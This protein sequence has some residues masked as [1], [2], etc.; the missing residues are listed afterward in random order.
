MKILIFGATGMLGHK[1]LQKF[2]GRFDVTATCRNEKGLN[3]SY[4]FERTNIINGVEVT[5][6]ATVSS[7]LQT[8]RPDVVVNA[9]G[10][11]KQLPG[12]RDVTTALKVNSLFPH[13]LATESEIHGFRLLTIS[14]DCVFDGKKGN[15]ADA[16]TPDALDLYGQSKRWGEVSA[17]NC[18]TLRTSIIGHELASSHSLVDWFL[19]NRGGSVKGFKSA[20]YSGFPTVIFADII[21]S[22]IEQQPK[23]SGIYNVS[24]E[25]INKFDLLRLIDEEYKSNIDIQPDTDFTIDRSLNS[26]RFRAETGFSPLSWPEMI[27]SMREDSSVYGIK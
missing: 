17:P 18:L 24:S 25:P 1:L 14:T 5:D 27:R 16:D 15:Y 23:L 9:A 20:I 6:Q 22:L 13:F 8:V 4:I 19:S 11:I 3:T 12:S 10:V 7:V 2:D 26:D 21:A